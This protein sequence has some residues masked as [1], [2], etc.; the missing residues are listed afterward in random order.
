MSE[1]DWQQIVT[2]GFQRTGYQATP[3]QLHLIGE[4]SGGH[5]YLVQ[6]ASFF[7]WKKK[8]L[9]WA[10]AE[11]DIREEFYEQAREPFF[12]DLWLE[13]D[14]DA[15]NAIR[16]ILKLPTD[17]KVHRK[18][19]SDLKRR[20]LLDQNSNMLFCAPFADYLREELEQ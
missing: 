2:S 12:H 3:D 13:Q 11:D 19:T 20:G 5:P 9:R 10:D 6:I 17:Y 14:Q 1:D 4:L 18:H 15:K 16:E 7:A 8:H